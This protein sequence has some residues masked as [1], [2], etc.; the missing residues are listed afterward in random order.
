MLQQCVPIKVWAGEGTK[1]TELVAIVNGTNGRGWTHVREGEKEQGTDMEQL[2]YDLRLRLLY[3]AAG[4]FG[5]DKGA[6]QG[7]L[8]LARGI[9]GQEAV[10]ETR[11]IMRGW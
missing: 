9:Q 3:L 5:R 2:L 6:G 8:I 1:A 10:L 4:F 11:V 7:M